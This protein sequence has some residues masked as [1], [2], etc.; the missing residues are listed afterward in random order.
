M[1]KSVNVG[2][3]SQI[4]NEFVP[5]DLTGPQG[6]LIGILFHNKQLNISEISEKMTLS[7]ST[8]SGI[9]DRLEKAGRVE[10]IRSEKDRRVVEVRLNESF[11]KSF[12]DRHHMIE[13]HF[14]KA[15]STATEEELK[16]ILLGLETLNRI[17]K[18]N[19]DKEADKN[20]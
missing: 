3:M 19:K 14:S 16:T 6:M 11:R 18:D 4:K 12:K 17:I 8:V 13:D 20:V 7:N 5:F 10:R 2:I 1:F 15:I 9:V